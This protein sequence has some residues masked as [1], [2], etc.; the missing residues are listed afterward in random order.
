[1]SREG[2]DGVVYERISVRRYDIIEGLQ[3]RQESWQ[4]LVIWV[5]WM[6]GNHHAFWKLTYPD[7][8]NIIHLDKKG[9]T[10]SR[11]IDLLPRRVNSSYGS[12]SDLSRWLTSGQNVR[13]FFVP[14]SFFLGETGLVEI[15]ALKEK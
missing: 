5:C 6:V 10:H 15:V 14:P 4:F 13:L 7:S 12:F 3:V 9:S 2:T 11:E 8:R 1:M